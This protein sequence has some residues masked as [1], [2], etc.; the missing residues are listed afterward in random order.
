MRL[1]LRASCRS[2][3]RVV[4]GE[5]DP[6]RPDGPPPWAAEVGAEVDRLSGVGHVTPDDGHGSWQ[7]CL[8]WCLDPAARIEPR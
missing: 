1:A 2:P 7:S 8:D 4:C 6:Y 5:L 3:V